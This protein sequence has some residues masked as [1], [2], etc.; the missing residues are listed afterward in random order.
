MTQSLKPCPFC[1]HDTP[2]FERIGTSR[3]SCIVVCGDCGA[4]HESSD[5]YERSGSSWNQRA[6]PTAQEAPAEVKLCAL[7]LELAEAVDNAH[8]DIGGSRP[9]LT[10]LR[11]AVAE[12][13]RIKGT[14]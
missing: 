12:A 13:Q 11:E 7:V 10:I 3:Q 14:R 2:E 6:T 1:G 9:Q 5:E 8:E 4:R